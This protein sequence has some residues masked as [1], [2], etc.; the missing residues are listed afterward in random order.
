MHSQFTEGGGGGKDKDK[1]RDASDTLRVLLLAKEEELRNREELLQ[2]RERQVEGEV[3]RQLQYI[4][5]THYKLPEKAVI[6]Q[7]R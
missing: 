5:T 7:L 1:G 3:K 6:Q 2:Q 4:L